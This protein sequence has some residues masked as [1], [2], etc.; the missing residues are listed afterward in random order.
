LKDFGVG[1]GFNTKSR[2]GL[3]SSE[4]KSVV[5]KEL[6]KT[7]APEFL[8]RIDDVIMFNSLGKEDIH[9][10]I[11]VELSK[12]YKR[13]EALGYKITITEEAKDYVTEKGYD[14]NYGARP[15]KRAIQKYIEDPMAE[16][17]IKSKMAEGDTLE[18]GFDKEKQELTVNV[19]KG[20]E[21]APKKPKKAKED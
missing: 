20:N 18:V 8:N 6:K 9:K 4:E 7:F 10:I 5:E 15:L 21:P 13:I 12:L 16:E 11:D 1:V 2:E 19:I 14:A 17:I 3:K